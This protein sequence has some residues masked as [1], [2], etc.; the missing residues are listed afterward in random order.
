MAL[1]FPGQG[2]Q[3]V[4]MGQGLLAKSSLTQELFD[5]A[6]DILGFDLLQ[7]CLTGPA[8]QL[9]RTEF[10]QPALYVHSLAALAQLQRER[11][12]L[13]DDVRAVAGLSLGEY[14]AIVA[15]GGLSFADGLRLVHTRGLAMQAAADQVSSGMA[16]VIGLDVDKL[17]EVCLA[18]T[19][20][21]EFVEVANL[22]CPGNIAISGHT[23]AIERA[24]KAV[25]EAGAMKAI[26]LAVAGAF[27]TALMQPAVGRLTEAL[28]HAQFQP[29]R[30]PVYSNVDAAAHSQPEQL[31]SLLARQ[32]IT[33]VL[34]EASL[35]NLMTAGMTNF[36][37]VGAGKVLAG[38]LKRID[39]KASCESYGD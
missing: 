39:R 23:A 25:I 2:A 28:S 36:I 37:E 7:L 18:A 12:Q 31:R 10:S 16:S 33:P 34:W 35:R 38:T 9:H 20:G 5:Q 21:T 6:R 15:A 14:T 32:I 3:T 19:Q 26:R 4:G 17:R 11:P 24:E 29:T 1:L 22:L 8:E 27:H 13:W 30:V